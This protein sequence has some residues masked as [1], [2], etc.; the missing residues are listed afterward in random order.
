MFSS[1]PLGKRVPWPSS[2]RQSWK[3]LCC[4]WTKGR[5]HSG[6][7]NKEHP[8][9][10]AACV[11]NRFRPRMQGNSAAAAGARGKESARR[12]A[13]RQWQKYRGKPIAY[14]PPPPRSARPAVFPPGHHKSPPPDRPCPS[15]VPLHPIDRALAAAGRVALPPFGTV[16]AERWAALGR[17]TLASHATG[18]ASQ[19]HRR[20]G[21]RRDGKETLGSQRTKADGPKTPWRYSPE[22][23]VARAAARDAF[24]WEPIP[25]DLGAGPRTAASGDLSRRPSEEAQ[26]IARQIRSGGDLANVSIIVFRIQG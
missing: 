13:C 26:R 23:R 4:R 3:I 5:W 20:P 12:A 6:Q 10:R 19:H 17:A 24:A 22:S 11:L 18:C 21:R 2:Q 16:A 8:F 14:P 9:N 7:C 15:T 1:S 25:G